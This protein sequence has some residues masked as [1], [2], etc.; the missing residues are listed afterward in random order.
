VLKLVTLKIRW[1][2]LNSLKFVI[3]TILKIRKIRMVELWWK[4]CAVFILGISGGKVPP[5]P[6]K[7]FQIPLPPNYRNLSP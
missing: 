5:P 7:K 1:L 3:C 2:F 6:K 4:A